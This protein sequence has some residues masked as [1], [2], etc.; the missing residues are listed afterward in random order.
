MPGSVVVPAVTVPSTH[1]CLR[2]LRRHGVDTIVVSERASPAVA[3]SR[4][5][6]ELLRV[7]SPEASVREYGNA[8][9]ELA[10]RED[11]TT[12][13]PVRAEDVYVLSKHKRSF[14]KHVGTPWP[15]F[16]KLRRVHDRVELFDV[17]ESLNVPIPET[18]LL[19]EWDDWSGKQIVKGR[20]ALLADAYLDAEMRVTADGD[21]R[22][23]ADGSLGG[24]V[25]PPSTRY[26]PPGTEPNVDA[27]REQAG[28]VPLVQEFMDD[29][30]EY[31]FF[32][33]YDEG[34]PLATFQHRQIRGFKYS[35][36]PSS[37][38]KSVDIPQ[39]E[40]EG[41]KLLDHLDWHGPA[42]VEFK[43]DS[44]TGEFKLMEI[45]PRFWSS[46]PFSVRAGADFPLYYWLL[47]TGRPHRID[48]GYEVGVGGHL[49]LGEVSYLNSILTENVSLVEK[50]SFVGALATVLRS[51]VR[52]P[53]FD[54]LDPSDPCPFFKYAYDQLVQK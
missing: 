7:P 2:S 25:T 37:F 4:Y 22:S 48:P 29:T 24:A 31:A 28:H 47:A 54:Y 23:M 17:A 14:A 42:M 26:L 16:E 40:R 35:G 11:V 43:R 6:D 13:V 46:L 50:P 20:Y 53:R 5:C 41:R 12:V 30:D 34:E 9:L 27:L 18:K 38:R 49:A 15:T 39:L 52:H 45:N 3:C 10:E 21:E 1:T 32:A 19:T 44:T 8:L 51:A 36:G 33:I